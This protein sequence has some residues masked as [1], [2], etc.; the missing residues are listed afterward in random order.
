MTTTTVA[1]ALVAVR[2]TRPHQTTRVTQAIKRIAWYY[3]ITTIKK[4]RQRATQFHAGA[5]QSSQWYKVSTTPQNPLKSLVFS[6]VKPH[7]Y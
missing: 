7:Q 4:D 5:T 3:T 6:L 2:A 1:M